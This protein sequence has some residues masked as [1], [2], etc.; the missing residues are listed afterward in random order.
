MNV[1]KLSKKYLIDSQLYVSLMGTC[2]AIFFMLNQNIFRFPTL[3]LIFITYFSGY[4]YTKYQNNKKILFKVLIFNCIC[5]FLSIFLIIYDQ[6]FERLWRWGIIVF[7]GLLYDSFFLKYFIRKIPLF[8]VFYV[9]LTWA[10]INGWLILPE[11]NWPIFF[12]SWLFITALVLPFDIRDMKVDDVVTFPQ[13]IGIQN[14]KYF[15]YLLVFSSLSIS[16]SY[17]QPI[18]SFALFLTSICTFIL[19][20]FSENDNKESYFSFW[21]ETCS[22]L[23]LLFLILLQ[24][25]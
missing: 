8:K 3:L 17:L 23:P 22:A 15:A 11:M 6:H 5:G 14:T 1:L 16:I 21:V 25:F 24:Y 19:I 4:I 2:L 9:G 7:I 12:I 20:Y 18:Y 10:L 13:L